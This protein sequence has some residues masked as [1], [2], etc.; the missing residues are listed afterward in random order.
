MFSGMDRTST[1]GFTGG[2][3]ISVPEIFVIAFA[4]KEP[5]DNP[6]VPVAVFFRKERRLEELGIGKI[7]TVIYF[8]IRKRLNL[9]FITKN[10]LKEFHAKSQRK[11]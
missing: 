11:K 5:S 2:G 7:V 4:A 1:S 8:K 3:K 9:F 10:S 6:I